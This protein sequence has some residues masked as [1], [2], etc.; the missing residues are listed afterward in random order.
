MAEIPLGD[1]SNSLRDFEEQCKAGGHVP[2]DCAACILV[3]P[4]VCAQDRVQE[5]L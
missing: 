3:L 1:L 4:K 2:V 5:A